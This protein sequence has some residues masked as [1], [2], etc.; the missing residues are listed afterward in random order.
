MISDYINGMREVVHTDCQSPLLGGTQVILKEE[1]DAASG[2]LDT[3]YITNLTP[4]SAIF[5][6]DKA[7]QPICSFLKTEK[8]LQKA[9]DAIFVTH[10]QGKNYVTFCEL[11][12]GTTRGSSA[13][14]KSARCLFDYLKDVVRS[15]NNNLTELD[16]TYRYVL[17]QT[18]RT[19]KSKT[20]PNAGD[21][22]GISA[23]DPLI[24]KVH[25]NAQLKIEQLIRPQL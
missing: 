24:I 11:K 7:N 6:P 25:N 5:H 3:L 15:R 19:S 17:L 14:L 10:L 21:R 13:Q 9:C 4:D 1:G 23:D 22:K 20:R 18:R 16:W 12:S 8:G 2:R